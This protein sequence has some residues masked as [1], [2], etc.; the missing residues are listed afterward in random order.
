MWFYFFWRRFFQIL[1][2]ILINGRNFLWSWKSEIILEVFSHHLNFSC[3]M[4]YHFP[5]FALF[6]FSFF[7][8]RSFSWSLPHC[9]ASSA[10]SGFSSWNFLQPGFFFSENIRSRKFKNF[11]LKISFWKNLQAC[12]KNC[13]FKALGLTENFLLFSVRKKPEFLRRMISGHVL[14]AADRLSK[15]FFKKISDDFPYIKKQ[16]LPFN[17]CC[18]NKI[19]GRIKNTNSKIGSPRSSK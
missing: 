5:C 13:F 7:S 6:R 12:L 3:K 8:F 17:A 9:F 1:T 10:S 4:M 11:M 15:A 16:A 2:G 14:K 18:V 19:P